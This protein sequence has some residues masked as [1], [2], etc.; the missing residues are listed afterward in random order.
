ML[1]VD[2]FDD[3]MH[4]R[5]KQMKVLSAYQARPIDESRLNAAYAGGLFDAE[6]CVSIARHD[7]AVHVKIAQRASSNLL[8]AISHVVF[9]G[10]GRVNTE[11]LT[12][13][14]V[15]TS[16]VLSVLRAN[17]ICKTTQIEIG[18]AAWKIK[19]HSDAPVEIRKRATQALFERCKALKRY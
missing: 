6:G 2:G 12:F 16:H 1:D 13:C 10:R 8:R 19:R 11:A 14:V 15:D 3:G 7:H 5:L 9:N 18:F 17:T 4:A